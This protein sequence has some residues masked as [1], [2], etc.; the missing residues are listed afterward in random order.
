MRVSAAAG[1][2]ALTSRART[3]AL[4]PWRETENVSRLTELKQRV[5][6]SREGCPCH[7]SSPFAL[8]FHPASPTTGGAPSHSPLSRDISSANTRSRTVKGLTLQHEPERASAPALVTSKVHDAI[9]WKRSTGK[10][11]ACKWSNVFIR[12][13]VSIQLELSLGI[14]QCIAGLDLVIGFNN[15]NGEIVVAFRVA[16]ATLNIEKDHHYFPLH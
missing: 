11:A 10:I 5:G 6:Q 12:Y 7:V 8:F 16:I 9:P 4:H 2:A 1:D 14:A 13:P 15:A 3:I